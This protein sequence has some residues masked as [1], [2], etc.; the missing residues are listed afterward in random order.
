M[1]LF[2][3]FKNNGLNVFLFDALQSCLIISVKL[4][5]FLAVLL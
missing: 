5:N 1:H 2:M 3:F 4:N